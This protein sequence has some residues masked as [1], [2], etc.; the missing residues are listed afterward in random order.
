MAKTRVQK[1]ELA[2]LK[3]EY[4]TLQKNA[5]LRLKRLE[6]LAEKDDY[7]AVLGYAYKDAQYDIMNKFSTDTGRFPSITDIEKMAGKSTN[8]RQMRMYI[9]SIKNFMEEV[10]STKTGIDKVYRARAESLN[11]RYNTHFKWQDLRAFF[12]SA[13]YEKLSQKVADSDKV[14]RI[15][16][17]IKKTP[18]KFLSEIQKAG[19]QD[20]KINYKPLQNVDKLDLN[21]TLNKFVSD[22]PDNYEVLQNLAEIFVKK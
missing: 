19:L 8:I 22:N 6:R 15:I 17:Q 18:K 2:S 12:A 20:R 16:A 4:R 21:D 13:E 7:Q 10:S 3:K 5:N 1:A 14:M 9:R 11:A